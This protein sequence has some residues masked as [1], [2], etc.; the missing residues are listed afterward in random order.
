MEGYFGVWKC[1]FPDRSGVPLCIFC[2]HQSFKGSP[3]SMGFLPSLKLY[4][5][6]RLL[7]NGLFEGVFVDYLTKYAKYCYLT[8]KK[9]L[10]VWIL[11][12]IFIFLYTI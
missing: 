9:A 11:S 5:T 6:A 8:C 10:F 4:F 1:G 7:K 12:S 3:W 2:L